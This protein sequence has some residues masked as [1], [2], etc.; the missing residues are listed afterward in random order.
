MSMPKYH[1][2]LNNDEYW[3]TLQAS[4][5]PENLLIRESKYT[6]ILLTN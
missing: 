5:E 3:L 4:V 2:Y 6:E 1:I